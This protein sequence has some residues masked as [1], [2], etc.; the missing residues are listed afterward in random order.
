MGITTMRPGVRRRLRA[1][2]RMP[3]WAIGARIYLARRSRGCR[4]IRPRAGLHG[5]GRAPPARCPAV[6]TPGRCRVAL[7]DRLTRLARQHRATLPM[8][9]LAGFG[10]LMWRYGAGG[11]L[12]IATVG[13]GR[14][15]AEF[16]GVAGYFTDTLAVRL[17]H[18]RDSDGVSLIRQ[19]RREMLA[20]FEHRMAPF[21]AV[22]DAVEPTRAEASGLPLTSL[23]Y[24]HQRGG[25]ERFRLGAAQARLF[26]VG[27]GGAK[28]GLTLITSETGEGVTATL[29]YD[30]RLFGVD[31]VR[32]L[33]GVYERVLE[34]LC[35]SAEGLVGRLPLVCPG[36]VGSFVSGSGSGVSSEADLGWGAGPWDLVGLF[37]RSVSAHGDRVAVAW[38]VSDADAPGGGDGI[39]WAA[40]AGAGCRR[41]V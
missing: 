35:G 36:A 38:P 41:R 9:L 10:A 28:T 17:Q 3:P 20:A 16:D 12:V 2:R 31:S 13:G 11:D 22:V 40:L 32:R 21:E 30:A 39:D 4:S 29:E 8:A 26:G 23:M 7:T 15:R 37:G 24:V 34:G 1:V 33:L 25:A 14:P 27:N 19:A 5:R 18:A 6:C